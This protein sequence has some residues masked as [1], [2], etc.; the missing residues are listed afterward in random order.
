MSQK[1]ELY[2]TKA[3]GE[4][5][6][7]D[8]QKL[9]RSMVRSGASVQTAEHV[10]A[11]IERD[12]EQGMST[13][14]IYQRAFKLLR[15]NSVKI[16]T[17]YNLKHA[18]MLLGP[19]GYPFELFVGELFRA[20]GYEVKVGQMLRGKCVQHEVDV[21]AFRE[22]Y[23]V[24][25]ECKFRNQPGSKTD[26]KVALYVHSRFNDLR[27]EIEPHAEDFLKS[28][29][30]GPFGGNG[31]VSGYNPDRPISMQGCIVT[32]A[33]FTE[34]AVQYGNC[35]N[36]FLIGWDHEGPDSLLG[37]IR[38]TKRVPVTVL[39]S[40]THNEITRIIG[41]GIVICRDLYQKIEVVDHLGIDEAKKRRLVVELEHILENG[42]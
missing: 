41:K 1:T 11:D 29:E 26:V 33:K 22:N 39:K 3:S 42:S 16:A 8:R 25:C 17:Q 15:Q 32:N 14:K 38:R 40:I 36:M 23:L 2:I 19:S 18:M 13:R 21:V 6:L 9:I 28:M 12:I 4:R 27:N 10:A 31:N 20:E 35:S 24:M 34:D 5:S 7:Y 30:F 37:M